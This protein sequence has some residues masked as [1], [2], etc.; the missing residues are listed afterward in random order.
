MDSRPAAPGARRRPRSSLPRILSGVAA[1]AI[2]WPGI[3]APA[4]AQQWS[5]ITSIDAL[6]T[7]TDNADFEARGQKQSDVIVEVVP[8]I[9]F[10]RPGA[11]LR[12][13]GSAAL[14]ALTYVEGTRDSRIDPTLD[15]NLNLEAIE[16]FFYIDGAVQLQRTYE[17]PFGP[18][19]AESDINS[20][21]EIRARISPYIAGNYGP[22]W[23]YQ[24]RNDS[25][26]V[27]GRGGLFDQRDEF[28]HRQLAELSGLPSPLG[29]S[30]SYDRNQS[31][32]EGGGGDRQTIQIARASVLLGDEQLFAGVRGGWEKIDFPGLVR[33]GS[34]YGVSLTWR[35]SDRTSLSGFVERRFFGDGWQASFDHRTADVAWLFRT[36]RDISTRAQRAQTL[37]A[38]TDV[39]RLIDASLSTSVVDPVER[40]RAVEDL[41]VSRG[42]P[43]TLLSPVDVFSDRLE[44]RT[45]HSASMLLIGA[46]NSLTVSLFSLRTSGA[47]NAVG[48]LPLP[49]AVLD[50]RQQGVG[51]SFSHQLSPLS[52]L[53]ADAS[54]RKTKS[55]EAAS[56]ERTRQQTYQFRFNR[57]L[58]P[59]TTALFGARYQVFDST[60][61]ADTNETAVFVGV[62]HRFR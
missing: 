23:R 57:V 28:A 45:D 52:T 10:L 15:L 7:A 21:R 30:L 18:Q 2:A 39:A 62:G 53:N 38:G 14:R 5:T 41:I 29:L 9:S 26:W 54:W 13:G 11:R 35:P 44:L 55:L 24:L 60:L 32:I 3:G 34:I 33:E 58:S 51:L 59:A 36:S 49:Q 4:L 42:L 56:D 16:R 25:T 27:R 6:L 22:L 20:R 8:R 19:L 1:L 37:S 12:V 61:Q 47:T 31:D 46:R 43:R 40:A 17:N 48:P 50:N